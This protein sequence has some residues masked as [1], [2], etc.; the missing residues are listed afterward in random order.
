VNSQNAVNGT[1]LATIDYEHLCMI[2]MPEMIM[3]ESGRL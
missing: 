2:K 1:D 3:E